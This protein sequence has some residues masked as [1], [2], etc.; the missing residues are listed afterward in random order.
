MAG[1]MVRG[2]GLKLVLVENVQSRIL[3]LGF[4]NINL[5]KKEPNKCISLSCICCH[6]LRT[7]SN[8][9]Q[10]GF[11]E[12]LMIPFGTCPLVLD[13]LAENMLAWKNILSF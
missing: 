10:L 5:W 4:V 1:A 3:V 8:S 7:G 11:D 6:L 2:V 9:I 13:V 12:C